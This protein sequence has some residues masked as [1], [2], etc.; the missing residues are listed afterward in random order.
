MR[1]EQETEIFIKADK[2]FVLLEKG[3]PDVKKQLI[4]R[5]QRNLTD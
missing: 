3:Q 1:K 5:K 4:R 2:A